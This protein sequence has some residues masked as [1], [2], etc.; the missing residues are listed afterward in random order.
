[1][2]LCVLELLPQ[3]RTEGQHLGHGPAQP[4]REVRRRD[5]LE[6]AVEVGQRP[7]AELLELGVLG[8]AVRGPHAHRLDDVLEAGVPQVVLVLGGREDGA[9]ARC[10]G[11]ERQFAPLREVRVGGEGTVVATG[12]VGEVLD[13]EVAARGD[14][15]GVWLASW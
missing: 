15:A 9:S 5:A 12:W 2:D 7:G 8:P 11:L 3:I 13:L 6:P 10:G 1:M 14:V 4:A